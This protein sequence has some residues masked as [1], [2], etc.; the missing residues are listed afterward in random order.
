MSPC[1]VTKFKLLKNETTLLWKPDLMPDARPPL[2]R[3]CDALSADEGA[4]RL[5][6]AL[7]VLRDPTADLG[8]LSEDPDPAEVVAVSVPVVVTSRTDLHRGGRNCI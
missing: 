5:E 3:Y 4:D 8:R 7:G 1:T 2:L 6:A